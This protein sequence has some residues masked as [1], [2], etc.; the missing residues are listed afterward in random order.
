[1]SCIIKLITIVVNKI[2]L[3]KRNNQN[4][5]QAQESPIPSLKTSTSD[6]L[7]THSQRSSEITH[8]PKPSIATRPMDIIEEVNDSKYTADLHKFQRLKYEKKVETRKMFP[9]LYNGEEMIHE[10]MNKD[11]INSKSIDKSITV[12]NINVSIIQNTFNSELEYHENN[13]N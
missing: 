2:K 7:P 13:H 8:F 12:N 4:I 9:H 5:N 3:K 1:M 10:D 6:K 11:N